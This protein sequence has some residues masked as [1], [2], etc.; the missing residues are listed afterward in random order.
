M[1]A[2]TYILELVGFDSVN[3]FLGTYHPL[4]A[5]IFAISITFGGIVGFFELYSG[6]SFLLWIFMIVGTIGDLTF[7][8]IA[9]LFYLNQ[10]FESKKFIRGIF[11]AFVLFAVIFITNIFKL[12]IEHSAIKPEILK[13]PFIYIIATIHYSFVLLIGIY[14]LLSIAENLAKMEIPVAISLTKILKVKIKRIEN[15]ERD[16]ENNNSDS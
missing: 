15:L 12:G 14:I 4:F 11:K 5:S 9:N 2:I 13:D 10:E 3:D 16:E 8:V 1:K 7:G 6:I